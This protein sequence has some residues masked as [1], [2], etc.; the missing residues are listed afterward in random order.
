MGSCQLIL[1]MV[2]VANTVLTE[3][4]YKVACSHVVFDRDIQSLLGMGSV[5]LSGQDGCRGSEGRG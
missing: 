3:R 4:V 5:M 2:Q 1:G